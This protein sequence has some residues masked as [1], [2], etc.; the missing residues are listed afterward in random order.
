[1]FI[2]H[3]QVILGTRMS[4][5]NEI[6]ELNISSNE[7]K[8]VRKY[9]EKRNTAVITTMFTDIKDFTLIT[10]EKGEEYSIK[11]RKIHDEILQNIIEENNV[12][13]VV[14]FIGDAV[15]AIFSEPSAA[16]ER[17]LMIQQKINEFNQSTDEF[18]NIAVRI[19]LHMG[20]VT[21]DDAIQADV[22][23]RH[24]NR[25][26]RIESL[27]DGGQIYLS[28]S[29]F[30]SA[31][32]W[33]ASNERLIWTLHGSYFLKGIRHPIEIYEV[34]DSK[35]A[36]PA[37]PKKGDKK[38]SIPK[39]FSSVL[40][41]IFGGLL[42]L[43]Y[44]FYQSTEVSFVRFYPDRMII[45][46]KQLVVL[47]GAKSDDARKAL[48]DIPAGA[49]VLHYDVS[50]ANRYYAQVN[51]ER[52]KNFLEPIFKAM[53]LPSLNHR[54]GIEEGNKN[55]SSSTKEFSY[56]HFVEGEKIE[57]NSSIKLNLHSQ[58]SETN[59]D[60]VKHEIDIV[61]EVNGTVI[62]KKISDSYDITKSSSKSIDD[63]VI[64]E[65]DFH[66]YI[67]TYYLSRTVADISVRSY[68]KRYSL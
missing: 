16:V 23:G 19:G 50:A 36:Q 44:S 42:A 15:M 58:I 64:F 30:D 45:D 35:Y 3:T 56:Y 68:F 26:S 7:I 49:H 28:Y 1:M 25:A 63:T 61:L 21:I 67:V 9:L 22:F 13:L 57:Y 51:I 48:I 32:G 11:L 66:K 54:Q 62:T 20:Q 8:N 33:L 2:N 65:D 53:R 34:V 29:V 47:D 39:S 60:S 14:K 18:E 5:E 24:V 37:P 17:A 55:A 40:L 59:P 38:R 31:K 43:G 10:E 6:D 4:A 46:G 41:V 27:A 12:G 52:G